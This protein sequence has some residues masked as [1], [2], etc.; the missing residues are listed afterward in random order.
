M[1]CSEVLSR[2]LFEESKNRY[3]F[4]RTKQGQFK[5][6]KDAT[7]YQIKD[8][9]IWYNMNNYV[10]NMHNI[11]IHTHLYTYKY[12][13][14]VSVSLRMS[15]TSKRIRQTKPSPRQKALYCNSSQREGR[16]TGFFV[17]FHAVLPIRT[18]TCRGVG[19]QNLSGKRNGFGG[20]SGA[21]SKNQ[22]SADGTIGRESGNFY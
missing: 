2:Y 11:Y 12:D 22:P 3:T 15:L 13:A 19:S 21:W 6:L 9:I 20:C 18:P 4:W 8:V 7:G 1:L 10:H 17:R 5:D 16:C 14:C